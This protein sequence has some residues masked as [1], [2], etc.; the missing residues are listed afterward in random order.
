MQE[1][2]QKKQERGKKTRE[3]TEKGKKKQEMDQKNETGNRSS[4]KKRELKGSVSVLRSC[5]KLRSPS[6]SVLLNMGGRT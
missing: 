1:M 3:R 2:E 6:T 4:R 5:S